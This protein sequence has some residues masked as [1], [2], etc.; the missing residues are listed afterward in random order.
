M[1]FTYDCRKEFDILKAILKNEP[2]LSDPNF[3][4]EFKLAVDASDTGAGKMVILFQKGLTN[5]KR[6]TLQLRKNVCLS[7]LLFCILKSI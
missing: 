7:F 1:H 5:I 6:I 4:K 3:A 2:V